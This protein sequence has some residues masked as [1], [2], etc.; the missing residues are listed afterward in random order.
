MV[1]RSERFCFLLEACNAIGI[2]NERLGK[3][4]DRHVAL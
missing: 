3:N 2:G 4:L 1:Q